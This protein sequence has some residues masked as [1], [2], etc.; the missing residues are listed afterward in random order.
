MITVITQP[1]LL[2]LKGPKNPLFSIFQKRRKMACHIGKTTE[3]QRTERKE[4]WREG[5]EEKNEDTVNFVI[6]QILSASASPMQAVDWKSL[7]VKSG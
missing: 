7:R 4:G 1:P 2:N 3:A 6:L 5:G